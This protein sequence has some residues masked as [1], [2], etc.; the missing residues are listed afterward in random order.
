M[1][2]HALFWRALVAFLV[3]PMTVAFIAPWL[4][5]PEEAG[6]G[7]RALPIVVSGTGL[8]LWCARDFYVAGRGTLL[9]RHRNTS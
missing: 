7:V 8:L 4:L 2:T 1:Q 5:L 6:F 9:G 3:L